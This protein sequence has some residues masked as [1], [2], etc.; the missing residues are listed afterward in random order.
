M[1][2]IAAMR[3]RAICSTV[4]LRADVAVVL[5]LTLGTGAVDAVS[6][7]SLNHV[8]TAN[9][10]GN[11]ALLGI[12]LVN[13]PSRVFGNVCS[14]AGFVCGSIAVARLLRASEGTPAQ[15]A[16][17]MLTLELGLLLLVTGALARLNIQANAAQRDLVCVVLAAAMGI[18]TGVARLLAVTDVNTT[19]ATMTLHDLVAGSRLAGGDS[20]RWR[21]RA[22]VVLA[23][24]A[25]AA[26]G[27]GL[28]RLTPAGG[29]AFTCVTVAATVVA[30]RGGFNRRPRSSRTRGYDGQPA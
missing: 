30:L 9:M 15:L 11:I 8:F 4:A 23:L 5:V 10:S 20:L 21:R 17:R 1:R 16:R 7:F 27:V 14:F 22:A 2:Y 6:Y 24:L 12:G 29:L 18:Q 19:V 3:P 13:G 25:G 28:D 26:L